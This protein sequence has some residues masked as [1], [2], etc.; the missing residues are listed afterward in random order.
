M[1]TSEIIAIIASGVVSFMVFLLKSA[2]NSVN[3]RL[4]ALG[5][6]LDLLSTKFAAAAVRDE[7]YTSEIERFRVK[8]DLLTVDVH[9]IKNTQERCK[10]CN[11]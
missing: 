6:K 2:V 5:E 4:D 1:S 8:I 3:D 9:K 10:H 11:S 7:N